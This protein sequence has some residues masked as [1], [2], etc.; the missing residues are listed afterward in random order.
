YVT[1]T[2][3]NPSIIRNP[4]SVPKALTPNTRIAVFELA[5]AGGE[6]PDI[7]APGAA[8]DNFEGFIAGFQGGDLAVS[9]EVCG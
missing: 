6:H 7:E 3:P 1:A 5:H 9:G 4:R 8:H 2:R